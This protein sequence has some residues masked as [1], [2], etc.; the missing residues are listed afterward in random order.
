M[1]HSKRLHLRALEP[2]DADFLYEVENDHEAWRYSDTIAPL[3]R[4]VLREYALTYDADP[5]SAGQLRLII[6]EEGNN[7]L[8]GI[9]DLYDVSSRHLRAF[10]GIYICTD[11]RKKGYADETIRL[12][13]EYAHNTLHLHQLGAKID[14]SHTQAV[15]LFRDL[16]YKLIGTF[17][18]WLST[19][20]GH[21]T[22]MLIMT[23]KLS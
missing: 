16:G 12:V 10:I 9:V 1:L 17:E 19:P 11:F 14:A 2:S 13:E 20:D 22:D 8:V 15:N 23:K 7:N 21:F 3:S 18:E 5:F 6:S 4:K